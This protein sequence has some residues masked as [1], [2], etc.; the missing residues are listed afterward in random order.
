[1]SDTT[2]RW[3][4]AVHEAAHGVAAIVLGGECSQLSVH[5][6]GGGLAF[7]DGLSPFDHAIVTAAPT[8]A[9]EI[10]A[11]VSPP[12]IEPTTESFDVRPSI[13]DLT[14]REKLEF[15]AKFSAGVPTDEQSIAAFCIAGLADQP[16]RWSER[17][18]GVHH[19]ADQVVSDH[20]TAILAVAREL[21]A[22][23]TL[24]K[25]EITELLK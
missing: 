18:Y 21:F 2:H 20:Q 19:I 16:L 23:G 14:P 15:A 10:L 17:F 3:A 6:D 9:A 25:S 12:E 11:D 22:R 5:H 24:S 7:L 8:A 4:T 13:C 1:M